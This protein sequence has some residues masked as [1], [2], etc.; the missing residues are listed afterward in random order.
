MLMRY[1]LNAAYLALLLALS[2]FLIYKAITTGKYRRGLLCKFLGLVPER[3]LHSPS[4]WFHG[5]S[6]GEIHLLRQVV[7]RFRERFPDW[8]CVIST[9]TDTGMEEAQ[10]AFPDLCVF[11]WPLDL[12]WAV[13]RALKRIRP[14][15]VILAEG[16]IWPNFILAA[17]ARA[18]PIAVINGRMSPRTRKHYQ[19][20][21]LFLR[22][23]LS[24]INL[25]C[26]QTNEYADAYRTL[27]VD[28]HRIHV[29]GS[30]KFDGVAADRQNPRTLGF[31]RLFNVHA[32]Q[33]VWIAGSTQAPEEELAINIFR[34]L[35]TE[36]PSLRLFIVPRQRERFDEVATLLQRSGLR[37][38]RRSQICE[39]LDDSKAVVLIDTIGELGAL[40]GLADISFVGGSLDG[41]R[42]GQNM[43]EPAAYGAAVIFG[44]HVWNF[45]EIAARLVAAE[46]AVQV[47]DGAELERV[48]KELADDAAQ[49]KRLGE[50]AQAFVRLQQGATERAVDVLGTLLR[51]RPA[52]RVAA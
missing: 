44:P 37:F 30:V 20:L 13:C 1:I 5:V 45:K 12:S 2:P 10:K 8:Q 23:I 41:R 38:V 33:T 36:N 15:L 21:A 47:A 18:V 28:D 27:G 22:P 51:Q 31:R 49:R 52:D 50:R 4:A 19:R 3:K 7:A 39:P 48:V 32:R 26:V 17:S 24:R 43:I 11:Y 9:T 46:A 34:R 42:G 29:T 6:V 40:W 16:E 14:T 35:S 25:F